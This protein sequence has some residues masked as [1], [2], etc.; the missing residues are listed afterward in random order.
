MIL[1]GNEFDWSKGLL[2]VK[3]LKQRLD[4]ITYTFP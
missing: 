2:L 1:Q 4:A 3:V